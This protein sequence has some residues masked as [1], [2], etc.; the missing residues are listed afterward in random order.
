[1]KTIWRVTDHGVDGKASELV[2]Y[3]G[4][5]IDP[6]VLK[7][8]LTSYSSGTVVAVNVWESIDEFK[9]WQKGETVRKIEEKLT[10]EELRLLIG[11]YRQK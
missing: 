3:F 2:G 7:E 11:H 8:K 6:P 5:E 9:Q 10:P 1:M 4:G